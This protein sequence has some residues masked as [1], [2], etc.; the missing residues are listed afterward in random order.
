MQ[1]IRAPYA[2][3]QS[4]GSDVANVMLPHQY[5]RQ[6]CWSRPGQV[7]LQAA[8]QDAVDMPVLWHQTLK[9]IP[10]AAEVSVFIQQIS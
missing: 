9:V 7:C 4:L 5:R 2:Y 3:A 1:S 10:A 8:R 6:L